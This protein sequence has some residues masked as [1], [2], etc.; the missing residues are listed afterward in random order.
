MKVWV[1]K[2]EGDEP[3]LNHV[4]S[5]LVKLRF[6]GLTEVAAPPMEMHSTL[7]SFPLS[8]ICIYLSL[9]LAEARKMAPLRGPMASLWSKPHANNDKK[10]KKKKKLHDTYRL[11]AGTENHQYQPAQDGLLVVTQQLRLLP[12]R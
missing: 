5:F 1:D 8:L 7:L 10:K 11:G 9:R 6:Y 4:H 12:R 2:G 3:D